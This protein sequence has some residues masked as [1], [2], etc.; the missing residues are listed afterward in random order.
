MFDAP[1]YNHKFKIALKLLNVY[2]S[3]YTKVSDE[4]LATGVYRLNLYPRG[5]AHAYTSQQWE[6]FNR[7]IGPDY[8]LRYAGNHVTLVWQRNTH[9]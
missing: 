5:S 3:S 6:S 8:A 2:E 4:L 9:S 7:V 1:L